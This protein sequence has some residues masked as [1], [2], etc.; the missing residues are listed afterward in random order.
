MRHWREITHANL[1]RSAIK[2]GFLPTFPPVPSLDR[3]CDVCPDRFGPFMAVHDP[4]Q[5]QAWFDRTV[6]PLAR[7]PRQRHTSS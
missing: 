1:L 3:R 5:Q 7:R 2:H 4:Y 6:R